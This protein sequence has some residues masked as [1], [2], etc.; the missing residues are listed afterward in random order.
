[1]RHVI[2]KNARAGGRRNYMK[3]ILTLIMSMLMAIGCIGFTAC[4]GS[5]DEIVV[6]TNAFFAPFEYYNNKNEIVGVDVE[7]MNKVGEELN[8]KVKF[9]NK[10]FGVLID[11]VSK[12]TLCDCSAAGITI[13]EERAAKV[14]FSIPYYTS[15]QFVIFKSG[16]VEVSKSDDNQDIVLWDALAGK[17]IGV[18]LDT[19][20]HIYVDLEINGDHSEPA[21][22]ENDYTGVLEGDGAVI[23]PLDTA[24]LAFDS[25]VANQLDVVVIDELPAKY[26]IK[27]NSEYIALP[28]YYD[29]ATAT[30][31]QYAIAVNKNKTELLAAIN[32]VLQELIEQVDDDNNN[33]IQNLVAKHYGQ[34]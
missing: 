19:T 5:D 22:P 2:E 31:E 29:S 13:T 20:G 10:D 14:A 30:E 8:K 27:N 12:G 4:G 21:D 25:M 3:K 9:E 34:K 11:E 33:G 1:M 18:Q 32:R 15:K 28:L 17:K 23:T 26:L 24:Q 6:Y 16:D 7:I